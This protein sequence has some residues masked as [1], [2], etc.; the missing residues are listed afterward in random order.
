[1]SASEAPALCVSIHDVA[2]S[3]WED[4]ARLAAALRAVAPIPLTWLVVPH[5]HREGGDPH[6]MRAGL[7]E[8][9][10]RGDELALHGYSH[11]DGAAP[12]GGLRQRYLREVYARREGEFA[13]LQAAEARRRIELGLAWFARRGWPVTGFVPP[14]WLM[15][16]GAWQALRHFSFAYITTFS[17]FHLLPG[18]P[19]ILSPS[20]VYA[21]RNRSGRRLSPVVADATAALFARAPLLR[22]SLHPPDL[23]HP[24]LVAHAQRLVERLLGRRQALTKAG[25]AQGLT[26]TDPRRP[27][28]ATRPDPIHH[29]SP[30]RY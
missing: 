30:D 11:H 1:M 2:P 26:S 3:T 28:C 4:C 8:A 12:G 22:L 9:L 29:S 19:A 10:A 24:A 15:G 6:A 13:A 27:R 23:H 25:F 18:G 7:D 17:R 16:E 20:M 5:Y 21:A 14:A